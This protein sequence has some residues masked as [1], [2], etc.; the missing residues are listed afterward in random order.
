MGEFIIQDCALLTKTSGVSA[1][2]N[3]RELR[4]RVASCSQNVLYHHFC[5]TPLVPAFDNPDSRNDFAVWAMLQLGDRILA[6]RLGIINPYIYLDLEQLR[7]QVLEI[8]DE[9]LSEVTFIPSCAQG[10][11]FFFTESVTVVFDTGMRITAPEELPEAI[12]KMTS[13][14]IYFHFLEARRRDPIGQD[15]F[16]A[17][18]AGFPGQ[19]AWDAALRGVD[20][21]F[22]TM[23]ELRGALVRLLTKGGVS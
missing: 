15:D 20:F 1:A 13:S 10:G 3:L 18:L 12:G 4:E 6:E 7:E 2:I 21:A 22:Y 23:S 17:W 11:E 5:E 14:S 16:S 9:R 8:L 19:E